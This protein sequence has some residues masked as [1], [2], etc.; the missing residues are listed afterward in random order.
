MR[1][2]WGIN[3]DKEYQHLADGTKCSDEYNFQRLTRAVKSP[4]EVILP[5]K[6]KSLEIRLKN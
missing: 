3:L 2:F 1:P 5:P 4:Q 6:E